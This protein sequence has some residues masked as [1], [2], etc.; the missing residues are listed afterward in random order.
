MSASVCAFVLTRNRKALLEECVRG[1]LAQTHPVDLVIVLDNASTDGTEEHLRAAGLLDDP[2]VRFERREENTGGA[3]GYREGVRLGIEAG[4]DW[5]WLMDDDAEPRQDAL[6]LLLGAADEGDAAVC[7]AVVHPDGAID[8]QHRCRMGRFIVPLDPEVYAAGRREEV[9][10]ASFVG[11]L[12]RTSAARAAGLPIAEFFIGYDDAEYS[13]RLREHGRIRLV[14]ESEILHKV[15]IGG[16]GA[17]TRRARFFNARFGL[18]YAPVPWAAFWRDLYRIRNF[19]WIKRD[20]SAPEFAV[21]TG[22]YLVKSL[23]YDPQ[24]LRRLPW[25]V[26]FA[27]KGR[28][29]DWSA[30]R[31]EEW[32]PS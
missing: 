16:G 7:S 4:R 17:A 6:E 26:R 5:L 21:L 27:R 29:G 31:P 25:L 18:T 15:P 1:L 11:L 30:P 13:L 23:M 8:L 10:C 22:G 2:R 19:M 24:P 12:V 3:G 32:P 20:V 14:P 9:E 28:R